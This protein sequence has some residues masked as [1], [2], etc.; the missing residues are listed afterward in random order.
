M[1]VDQEI[2]DDTHIC[3]KCRTTITGLDNYVKHR[4]SG[5]GSS[6]T[7]VSSNTTSPVIE[8]ATSSIPKNVN[9][10][11]NQE[12]NDPDLKAD[13]FFSSLEL[14]SSSKKTGTSPGISNKSPSGVLTRSKATA[15]I[16]SH[17][18]T[19]DVK[20]DNELMS[21]F[22]SEHFDTSNSTCLINSSVTTEQSAPPPHFTGGKWKPTQS[23]IST[24][25]MYRSHSE[26]EDEVSQDNLGEKSENQG[27]RMSNSSISRG[28]P[29]GHTRGKWVPGKHVRL[30]EGTA[31]GS[32][33]STGLVP[34]LR[35]LGSTVQYW[36]GPCNRR[37]SSRTLYERH[38]LSELHFKRT[39]QERELEEDLGQIDALSRGTDKRTVKRTEAYLNS[40][41]WQ[42]SKRRRLLAG[43]NA[44]TPKLKKKHLQRGEEV[45]CEV[46]NY[47]VWPHLVGKHLVSHYHYHKA[48]S[49]HPENTNFV[50]EHIHRVVKRA[51]FQCSPCK[52]YCNTMSDFKQHWTSEGHIN[53]DAKLNGRY[54]CSLCKHECETSMEMHHHLDSTIHLELVSIINRSVPIVLRKISILSCGSCHQEFRYNIELRRHGI[55]SG[56]QQLSTGSDEYQEKFPC[57]QCHFIGSSCASF[58]R[59]TFLAHKSDGTSKKGP[60]FCSACSL[61][62]DTSE[63]SAQHRKSQEHKYN[64]L[65][66]RK[67]RGLTD[68]VLT[69][70]CPHCGGN[71][72]NI[73]ALKAHLRE[74]HA[75]FP[76][77]CARC[78]M[79]FTLPQEVS[80]HVRERACA[81][82][83]AENKPQ[84]SSIEKNEIPGEEA[85]SSSIP[86]EIEHEEETKTSKEMLSCSMC[87]Y[88][89]DSRAELLF[90]E[91]LHGN[92]ISDPILDEDAE[93]Q[94]QVEKYRC[95]VC[96]REFR[97]TS[98]RCHLR[99]HTEERPFMCSICF[100]GFGHRS[101][102]L[103]H[104]KQTHRQQVG[105]TCEFCS[106]HTRNKGT[107]ERHRLTH[108][109]R[110]KPFLC[111]VCGASFFL[112]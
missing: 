42:L 31:S 96:S 101:S 87:P 18:P 13:D 15:V 38:L 36:C 67:K 105:Y 22:S 69:K 40:D 27:R 7:P 57:S 26:D 51:P 4:K 6:S 28:P 95:P 78:G 23:V 10:S 20:T 108:T 16:Q 85:G 14:Q 61:N 109:D 39:L 80:R 59:H 56:H 82:P 79:A 54:L 99:T 12:E 25:Q 89:T 21:N 107:M 111:A 86:E 5:C 48:R 77:R 41:I 45:L 106:F 66:S 46:C 94:T 49:G 97:K 30:G 37:L 93:P 81:F 64:S 90:H 34:P 17:A 1:E 58:Q 65:A 102:L 8:D 91:V 52:F 76:Y 88:R 33:G 9:T 84:S 55:R 19:R 100:R 53:T 63:E 47:K 73:L 60:Y 62:F 29:P 110:N 74:Q 68:D 112:K 98:L 43:T 75:E 104:I 83:A 70:S 2:D 11:P 92:P 72:E 71:F 32:S 3:L 103:T 35:K 24:S 44:V 50:L